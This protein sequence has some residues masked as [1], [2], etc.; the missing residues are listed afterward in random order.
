MVQNRCI[1][2]HVLRVDEKK[3]KVLVSIGH[4]VLHLPMEAVEPMEAPSPT[5]VQRVA[6]RNRAAPPKSRASSATLDLHGLTKEQALFSLEKC[7]DN[8][9][10][11]GIGQLKIIHGQGKGILRTAVR[12][13]LHRHPCVRKLHVQSPLYCMAGMT[14]VEL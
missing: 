8:A 7:I 13:Y 9:L 4:C 10:L 2:G 11:V 5:A 12:T 3:S 1:L 6:V 14:L